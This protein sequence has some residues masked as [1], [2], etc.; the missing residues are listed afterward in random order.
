MVLPVARTRDEAH[1]FCDLH[2]CQNCGS[3][4]VTW[5]HGLID[6]AGQLASRYTGTCPG[7]GAAREFLFALPDREV[8]PHGYP[9]FGGAEASQ[10]LDAGEWLRVADLTA[11]AIRDDSSG[12]AVAVA[13]AAIDE[14]VKFI[15]PNQDEV[16]ETAFWSEHG[17]DVRESDPSRFNRERLLAERNE[18]ASR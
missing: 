14:V 16:P 3:S 17:R 13:L 4:D 9:T 18:I 8:M 6:V 10:L 5:E 15:P 1:L 2:P 12:R 7:C 11:A